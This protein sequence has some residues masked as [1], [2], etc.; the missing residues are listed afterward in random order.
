MPRRPFYSFVWFTSCIRAGGSDHR[1]PCSIHFQTRGRS[2][3][4]RL[5]SASLPSGSACILY[6][7]AYLQHDTFSIHKISPL[8]WI[9][10]VLLKSICYS[11]FICEELRISNIDLPIKIFASVT[12]FLFESFHL[13]SQAKWTLHHLS[14]GDQDNISELKTWQISYWM[15]IN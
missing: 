5:F 2:S 10:K 7:V 13:A 12:Y 9:Y 14:A 6:G 15:D 11:Q 1:Y 3:K 4:W 8:N